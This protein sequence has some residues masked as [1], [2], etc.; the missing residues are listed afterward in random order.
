MFLVEICSMRNLLV[1][2]LVSIS[3]ISMG[4]SKKVDQINLLFQQENYRIVER[5]C[6]RIIKKKKIEDIKIFELYSLLSCY[7]L[8]DYEQGD[9]LIFKTN[10]LI[11]I[12]QAN[13]TTLKP[14]HIELEKFK[15]KME[16]DIAQLKYHKKE[17][18]AKNLYKSYSNC[19]KIQLKN[20]DQLIIELKPKPG[21]SETDEPIIAYAKT[22]IG[23]P[24]VYGG[25]NRK[26]FDCSGFTKD[27]YINYN[28]SL[29]RTAQDQS[30]F[31]EK[32]KLKNIKSGDLLFFGKTSSKI[33][34]V[35][36]AIKN[37]GEELKMIHASSSKGIIISTVTTNSYWSE[38]FQFAGRVTH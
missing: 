28:H 32:V 16:K 25:N 24:Y 31:C 6:N 30:N 35:G 19:F 37:N 10:E 27:V 14:S 7:M 21:L 13:K 23:I 12:F 8:T 36:I 15:N 26:G 4:Q 20:Y 34:H 29:P 2:L 11:Q 1:F 33:S 9:K 17:N 18:Q 22:Y 38:K 5:K 3:L